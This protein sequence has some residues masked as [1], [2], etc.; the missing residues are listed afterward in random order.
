MRP[1]LPERVRPRRLEE[2]IGHEKWFGEQGALTPAIRAGKLRSI[3]LWGP[4]GCGKTTIARAISQDISASF[5]QISAVFD[6]VKRLREVLADATG[7]M[8]PTLLFVDEIHRWNKAQ[9]DALLPNVERGDVTLVGAT[10]ENPS[11]EL[12][13][14]LRSRLQV[15]RLE[16][17][18]TED[19]R[20]VLDRA[21]THAEGLPE[22]KVDADVLDALS[23]GAAGDA[24]RALDDLDR[25]YSSIPKGETLTIERA[26]RAL[27]RR[28]VRHDR[29]GEDHYNVLS[30]LIKSMRGS[31]PDA[32]VYWLARLLEGGEDPIAVARRLVVFAAEDVGN[33]DPRAL[34][35]AVAATDAARL[36]GMP[37]ARIPLAQA[38][39]WCA[40]APKSNAAY[41]AI[42]AAMAE[43]QRSGAQAVPLHLRQASSAEARR[44][45][46]GD[47]YVYPHDEPHG[48]A[49]Q[50]HL[51]ETLAGRQ[52]YLPT[53]RAEEKRITERLAWWKRK[54]RD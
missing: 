47:G 22:A 11:F 40:C 6:G 27:Q 13:A 7:S 9:Q 35:I 52:F 8:I 44:A 1:P 2:I 53:T 38:V 43:V 31:D 16:P 41:L 23:L 5:V 4:P 17:L 54:L 33:A 51:P 36:V 24:R 32:A 10:T 20:R 3:V 46:F 39:L 29:G 48:I 45:G 14:A 34:Q 18:T 50:Q 21:L 30:A 28:D 42:N 26:Q 19:V 12:N 15:V 25:A 37:E 49:D